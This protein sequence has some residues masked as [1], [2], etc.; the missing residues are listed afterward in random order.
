MQRNEYVIDR[1]IKWIAYGMLL[2]TIFIVSIA[3]ISTE[4]AGEA[5]TGSFDSDF[6]NDGWI[7]EQN[8]VKKQIT[9]PVRTDTERG[10]L[11]TIS[12]QLPKD[13]NDGSSLMLRG[14]MSDVYVYINGELRACYDSDHLTHQSYYLPSAYVVTELS[15]RDSGA[16]IRVQFRIKA[17]GNLNEV[18]IGNGNNVW[19]SV[20]ERNIA[21]NAVALIV[22]T[23]GLIFAVIAGVMYRNFGD[24]AKIF[25]LGMLMM[26]LGIWVLSESGL[27]Q[28]LVRRA[29]LSAFY[30]YFSVELIC[31]FA[32]MFVDEAQKR[33]HHR[34]Y[35]VIE[36]LSVL[37]LVINLVLHFTGIKELYET[38]LF[39]HIFMALAIILAIWTILQDVRDKVI[40]RYK[41]TAW[42][43]TGF[44][45]MAAFELVGFY[46]TRAHIFGVFVC[47]GMI[48]L[49]TATIIQVLLDQIQF[50]KEHAQR[51]TKMTVNMIETIAGSID[52]KDEYTGG[53]SERVGQYAAVLA[54][55][56]AADYDFTEEDITRI[57]YIGLMHDIGKIGVADSVLNKP[58]RLTE[59]EYSLMKRH[60]DFGA[61]IMAGMDESIPGLADGIKYHHER[62]DGTGYPQGLSYTDI[63]LVARILC[64]ADCYDAMTSNRVYRKRLSDEAVR[65]KLLEGAG[66]Q[67]DP[68]LTEIFVRM[69]D[70]GEMRPYTV[71]GMAT[72]EM[73]KVLKS[74][75]L[76]NYLQE[77]NEAQEED[78]HHMEHVRM[79]CFIMK[80]KE[81]KGEKLDVLFVEPWK[82]SG[83]VKA[84]QV[85]AQEDA[86]E[87][88]QE[89]ALKAL[90][91]VWLKEQDM[92]IEYSKT[93]RIIVFFGHS[94]EHV[95]EFAEKLMEQKA[96]RISKR[97]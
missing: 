77:L 68:A 51:Q 92:S 45:A 90:L 46:V 74:S 61:E 27:R 59:E 66:T 96:G 47:V 11:L 58:G 94:D 23:I 72:W 19:F 18:R 8:G 43:L 24:S 52:A 21:V 10:E 55:G 14:S 91:K 31:V 15:E 69:I 63:P 6:Y 78:N 54:R 87:E 7:L 28:V 71:D 76:E 33:R 57:R 12:N 40:H 81:K 73:G 25:C 85:S 41:A 5:A 70:A 22:I 16:E 79:L 62:F 32:C 30:A 38:L 82:P 65:A 56:M 64:L 20:I 86:R 53:H 9:L 37:Q 97:L 49:A 75:F 1:V 89:A 39:S 13:L 29:S 60:V 3:M 67:F 84:A 36:G 17:H 4:T 44:V 80:L 2:L 42:G 34:W 88:M 48:I 26:D 93:L 95:N 83:P 50:S 35:A